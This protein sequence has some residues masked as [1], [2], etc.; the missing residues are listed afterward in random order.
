M[1][2]EYK[3]F[4]FPEF[5]ISKQ[6]FH[7][8][9][10]VGDGGFTSG[11]AR[12]SSPEPGGFAQLEIQPSLQLGEWSAPLSSWL[13]S[14]GNGQILRV[15]L[16]PTPQVLSKR[17][18]MMANMP[19][20][21]EGL[22]QE[23]PWS[24]FPAWDGDLVTTYTETALAGTNE[25][26]LDMAAFGRILKVGHVIGHENR[27]YLVDEITYAGTIATVV[28]TPP[29]RE[30]VTAGDTVLFRPWFTGSIANPTDFRNTYDAENVGMIQL[31]KII[32]N[33]VVL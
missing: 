2:I 16:A 12:V 28:V 8:P 32:L 15:R 6:L 33:E 14:K 26:T 31:N 30:D 13:M 18:L 4:D 27:T 23:A 20:K 22:K 7:V 11:G 29:L 3:V 19:W 17:S 5:P 1:T 25:L 9:G 24:N 21:A 10:A